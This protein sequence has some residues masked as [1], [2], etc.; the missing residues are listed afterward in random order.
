MIRSLM[1]KSSGWRPA[2][3][4]LVGFSVYVYVPLVPSASPM[5]SLGATDSFEGLRR[6]EG[7]MASLL[8]FQRFVRWCVCGWCV[9]RF[10]VVDVVGFE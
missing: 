7:R 2:L 10:C 8:Q 4:L 3:S 1:R 5:V 9:D 6:V